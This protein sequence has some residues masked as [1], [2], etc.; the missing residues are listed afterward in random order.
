MSSVNTFAAR[1]PEV[2]V[3]CRRRPD[4]VDSARVALGGY[5]VLRGRLESHHHH[6]SFSAFV[7]KFTSQSYLTDDEG[8]PVVPPSSGT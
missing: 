8:H 7:S 5:G 1:S 6:G 2:R 3:A 4:V